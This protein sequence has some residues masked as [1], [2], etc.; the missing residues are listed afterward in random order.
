ME[1]YSSEN[2][3]LQSCHAIARYEHSCARNEVNS[4]HEIKLHRRAV[5]TGK[6]HRRPKE[7]IQ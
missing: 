1:H 3:T 6:S 5:C 4:T 7:P 2:A